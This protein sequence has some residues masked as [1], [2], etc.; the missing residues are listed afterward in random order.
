MAVNSRSDRIA[1][2]LAELRTNDPQFAAA[3]PD[4]AVDAMV[5]RPELRM[6][7]LI[8]AVLTAYADR[9]A[10]G[11]RVVRLTKDPATGRTHAEPLPQY[12]TITYAELT[13]RTNAVGAALAQHGVRPGDRITLLGANGIDYTVADLAATKLGA[14]PVP[15]P[16]GVPV[17]QL[18]AIIAE[19]AAA[20][21][22]VTVDLL[23]SA[24]E[25]ALTGIAPGLLV[26]LGHRP[27]VDD[28]AALLAAARAALTTAAPATTIVTLGALITRGTELPVPPL[29][30]V[31]EGDLALLLYTSGSTGTPKGVEYTD[32]QMGAAWR[33]A[34][35]LSQPEPG[36]VPWIILTNLPM[37]HLMGRHALH[38]ALAVGGTAYFPATNDMTSLLDDLSLIRP[39]V[40]GMVPRMWDVVYQRFQDEVARRRPTATDLDRLE[41]DVT[42]ELRQTLLGGRQL[43]AVSGAAA[44]S[45]DLAAWVD[46]LLDL[47]LAD[48][49]GSTEAGQLT[50][51]GRVSRPW[52]VDYRLVDVPELGYFRTD[53]P[54]PRGELQVKTL[55]PFT[56]YYRHPDS[57]ADVLD[58]DGWFHTG[59]IFAEL[60]P[61]LVKYVDRRSTVQKLA[62]GEFVAVSKLE[63]VFA[64]SPLV[65]QI[66]VYGN[67]TRAYLLAVV[68][69]NERALADP[70]SLKRAVAQS[71]QDLAKTAGLQSYE[72]PRDF[73]VETTPFSQHNG[74]LTGVG[75]PARRNLVAHYGERLEDSYA[76][77]SSGQDAQLRTLREQGRELPTIETVTR[78][79]TALLGSPD[80]EVRPDARF[81]DLG[82]DSLSALTFVALLAE[83]YAVDVP[84][85]LVVSPV[86][87][88]RGLAAHLDAERFRT[89]DSRPTFASIHG[90]D[91]GEVS[92][93]DLTLERFLDPG[94]LASAP[95]LAAPA[96]VARKVLL[97]GATG[98]LGRF[99]VLDWLEQ[100]AGRS[101]RLV[102]LVRAKDDAT[103]RERLDSVFE[104]GDPAVPRAG[105]RPAGRGGRRQGGTLAGAGPLGLAAARG[106]RRPDRG[107]RRAGQSRTAVQ[108]AVRSERAG[109][110]RADPVRADRPAEA[111]RVRLHDRRRS[112]DRAPGLHRGRRHPG[113][114]PGAEGPG[115]VRQ[116][117][118]HQQVGR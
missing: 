71:F 107:L 23:P 70:P 50:I 37:G 90:R 76:A 27:E 14:V 105:R 6:P 40:L 41:A 83:I 80:D 95:G 55:L 69:P 113:D 106:D 110:R 100:L 42:A 54:Y 21:Q 101:G 114:Q 85:S 86:T 98:F 17:D 31:G 2:R 115:R 93:A 43:L 104:G 82:G 38:G 45:G 59:D 111:V 47:D 11:E 88:L 20:V 78:A 4:P 46:A 109:H 26:V 52:V 10:L 67:S 15:L 64:D 87:D 57:T 44:I 8:D 1:R 77:L 19:T 30:D 92:A 63:A 39:T 33:N 61:D 51:N 118:R 3:Q 73:L 60:A 49:Y 25:L 102:C 97:T 96:T 22:V 79:A 58:A 7:Q 65:H 89:E 34:Q 66:F 94:T 28:E 68:V 18:A 5:R 35:F 99:L 24:V 32:S 103:A 108:P 75:K 36:P 29:P 91:A 16:L 81:A 116:R 117:V 74:L 84:V 72:I 56:G 9:P 112:A 13:E 53:R 12:R 48:I 62:Q